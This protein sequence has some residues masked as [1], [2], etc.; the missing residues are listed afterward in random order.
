MVL[1]KEQQSAL[2]EDLPARVVA[3]RSQAGRSLSYV[4]GWYVIDR[5][6]AILG[7]GCWSYDTDARCVV[8]EARQTEDNRKRWHVTY[9]AKCVLR[10]GDATIGDWGTGHGIDKDRGASHESAIKEAATD[11]LKRCAKSLGRSLGLALYDKEQEHVVSTDDEIRALLRDAE[12]AADRAELDRVKARASAL[13]PH[14]PPEA[15]RAVGAAIKAASE[16]AGGAA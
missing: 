4:E 11:A 7:P 8:D 9:T 13:K 1:S 16:R 14:M 3:S 12:R 15:V 10:V 6:N 2:N 5:L